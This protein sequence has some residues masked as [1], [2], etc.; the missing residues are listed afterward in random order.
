VIDKNAINL[1][2]LETLIIDE[3]DLMLGMGFSKDLYSIV[4]K[5]P[6]SHQTLLFSATWLT[7]METLSKRILDNFKEVRVED[8]TSKAMI[9]QKVHLIESKDKYYFLLKIIRSQPWKQVLVFVNT[10][11]SAKMIAKKLKR[12]DVA[13][14]DIHSDK[15]QS[16]R[17]RAIRLFKGSEIKVLV[18][19]DVISRGLDVELLPCIINYDLPVE[20]ETYIHRIGRTGRMYSV[21]EAISLVSPEEKENLSSIEGLLG[22]K[23]KYLNLSL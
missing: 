11:H 5:L 15:A 10:R 3:A 20:P 14:D 6:N 18:A 17:N 2:K 8:R 9:S 12:D 4:D 19:T 1:S 22:H 13:A 7:P 16:V 23:I 21:G